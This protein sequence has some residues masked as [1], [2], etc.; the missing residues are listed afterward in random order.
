[1]TGG[2]PSSF[3][4]ELVSGRGTTRHRRVV[5]GQPRTCSYDNMAYYALN[6]SEYVYR[7]YSQCRDTSRCEPSIST[8][9][10]LRP[11]STAVRFA[12][13][14][15]RQPRITAIE[16]ETKLFPCR[17]LSPKFQVAGPLSQLL[18]KQ[19]F[20]Q[21]HLATEPTRLSNR[22]HLSLRCDVSEH[23]P[24]PSTMLRMVPLPEPSSGRN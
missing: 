14:L 7:R 23:S 16:V 18:P 8:S 9:I 5:E 4:P 15:D 3:L 17:A 10:A 6:I 12:I 19:N 20:W 24:C 11:V 1:M 21:R 13:D 2:E 22:L